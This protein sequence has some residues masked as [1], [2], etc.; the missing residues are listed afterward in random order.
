VPPLASCRI[1]EQLTVY[2]IS[3]YAAEALRVHLQCTALRASAGADYWLL[4]LVL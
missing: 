3:R 4:G 1:G 2:K